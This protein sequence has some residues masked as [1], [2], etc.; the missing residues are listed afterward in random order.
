MR[1]HVVYAHPSE[2]SFTARIRDQFL[3]GLEQGG[4]SY[5]LSDLYAKG[6]VSDLSESEYRREA[7]YDGTLPVAEDVR[8]EQEL[9][10]AADALVFIYPLFWTEAPAKLVGWFSRVWTRGYAS[11][12]ATGPRTMKTLRRA[13]C[14]CVAGYSVEKHAEEGRLSSMRNIM[15]GDRI[16]DRATEKEL[17]VLG[18][19]DKSANLARAFA[20]ARD[21]C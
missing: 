8:E 13:L 14:L 16:A 18:G 21:F 3:C 4:H 9:I 6:F 11:P 5:T 10:E 20:I 12:S 1:V 2:D 19:A 17:I 7:S 15:L